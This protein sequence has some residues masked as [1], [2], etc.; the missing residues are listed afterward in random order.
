MHKAW[1]EASISTI[2]DAGLARTFL[3]DG[4]DAIMTDW[5]TLRDRQ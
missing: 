2:N 5:P 1:L 3:D 4:A